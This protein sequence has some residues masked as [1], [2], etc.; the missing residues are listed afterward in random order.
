MPFSVTGAPTGCQGALLA[1]GTM[2]P[3]TVNW[4]QKPL[5]SDGSPAPALA[6]SVHTR[7]LLAALVPR[8]RTCT[9]TIA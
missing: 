3:K 8:L 5:G 7:T 2:S 1:A 4:F 6:Y 9:W